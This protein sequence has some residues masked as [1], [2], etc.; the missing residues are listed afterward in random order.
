M[1]VGVPTE[2]KNNEYR[3]A[4]TAACV[5]ELTRNG[6][7]VLVESGAGEGSAISDRDYQSAGASV[8]NHASDVW[9]ASDLILKVKEPVPA[10]FELMQPGQVLFTYLHLA[11]DRDCAVALVESDV[12]AIAY[13]T[14]QSD[15]GALP[16]LAPMSEVA[17][18]LAMQVGAYHL[19]R[20]TGGRGVLLGGVAGVPPANVVVIGAGVSGLNAVSMAVGMQAAVTVLDLD[21]T[22]L[23][24]VDAMYRGYCR[25]VASN[26]YSIQESVAA[27]DLVV[28]AVLVPG[29]SAPRLV[30]NNLVASMKQGSVL[31]DVAIDQGGCFA[32]SHP[33]THERPTFEVQGSVFY[34]VANM[35]GAVPFTSTYALTNATLPY[36]LSI[37]NY[38][39]RDAMRRNSALASGLNTHAGRITNREVASSLSMSYESTRQVLSSLQ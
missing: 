28:G 37:A 22:R 31:V 17:G 26:A 32:D 7:E 39:W 10:E 33:T 3:V 5:M 11:A 2:I 23:R 19:S 27:A 12:T 18:R 20:P 38:G 24:Y 14:V 15:D 29:A 30:D 13:E 1:R 21:L 16:L 9:H 8:L 35:P 34:C 4:I 6:H 25:T 36:V